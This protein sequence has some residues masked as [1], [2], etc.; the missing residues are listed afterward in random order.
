MSHFRVDVAVERTTG[1]Q[2]NRQAGGQKRRVPSA[3]ARPLSSPLFQ[4]VNPPPEEAQQQIALQQ[5]TTTLALTLTRPARNEFS[6]NAFCY[7]VA[8]AFECANALPRPV[9]ESVGEPQFCVRIY[10]ACDIMVTNWKSCMPVMNGF[11][12][13]RT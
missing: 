10:T 12:A 9:H 2:A 13:L 5:N 6:P 3:R 8:G 11:E 7:T 1:R 4:A